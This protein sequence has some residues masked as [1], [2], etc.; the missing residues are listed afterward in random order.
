MNGRDAFVNPATGVSYIWPIGH[1]AEESF[2]KARSIEHSAPTTGKGLIRQQG[3][4]TPMTLRL[5]GTILHSGQHS[6]F[7]YWWNLCETQTIYFDDFEDDRYE[8]LIL[9]FNPTRQRTL[10]NSRDP[11]IPHHYWTYQLNLEVVR[12]I[13]GPWTGVTP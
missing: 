8:V 12:F 5:T 7:I 2:G 4:A 3:A 6:Q 9:D 1:D 11:S 13:S 10:R